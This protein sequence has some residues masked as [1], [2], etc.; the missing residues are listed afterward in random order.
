[1]LAKSVRIVA[2]LM[3]AAVFG[4][5]AFAQKPTRQERREEANSRSAMGM[6]TGADDMPAVGAVAQLKDMRTLQV[7]SFITQTDGTYNFYGLK[8]DVEYQLN[9]RS[10]DATAPTR[11]LSV[12][13]SRKEAILN[14]KLEV[15]NETKK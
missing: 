10:G 7:R 12:F 9:A 2:I 15:K 5:S 1:L 14:F 4:P 6:I 13:D 11:T 8:A 3:V